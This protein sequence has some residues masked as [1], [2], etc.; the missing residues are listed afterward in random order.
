MTALTCEEIGF[1]ILLTVMTKWWWPVVIIIVMVMIV[2]VVVIVVVVLVMVVGEV[3]DSFR[4]LGDQ[5]SSG[6]G[7][8]ESV[9]ARIRI[10]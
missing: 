7:Y 5:V 4:Y 9:A 10:A 2:V 1:L 6:S 8:S 3:V